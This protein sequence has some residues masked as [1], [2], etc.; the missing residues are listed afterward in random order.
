M[1]RVC[2][3]TCL[4]LAQALATARYRLSTVAR[5]VYSPPTASVCERRCYGLTKDLVDMK[6]IRQFERHLDFNLKLAT[7][8]TC[9]TGGDL[10]NGRC[11]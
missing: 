1:V 9:A 11:T 10:R 4:G 7:A 3:W 5:A 8:S 2:G 6:L